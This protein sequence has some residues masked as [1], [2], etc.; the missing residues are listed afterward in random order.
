MPEG[1]SIEATAY[2]VAKV[3][4]WLKQQPEAKIITTYIGQG[5]PRFFLAMSPELPDPSFGKIV[6]LT[7]NGEAREALKQRLRQK[8]AEGLASEARL[9]AIELV[10][11]PYSPFPVA[12]RV[13]G[14]D[15]QVLRD[16]I[17]TYG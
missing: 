17:Q 9:R 10:F 7:A 6:I 2:A 14:P 16:G 4:A 11:G 15:P 13:T 5:A 1:S 8:I 12:F 3:E